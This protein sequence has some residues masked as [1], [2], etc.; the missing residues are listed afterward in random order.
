M[1]AATTAVGT[2]AYTMGAGTAGAVRT[3]AR[4]SAILDAVH[5]LLADVGYAALSI[6]AVAARAGASK[7]TIYRHWQ[8]KR[9]LVS[10][11]L[12]ARAASHPA[13]PSDAVDL[14]EDLVRL[15]ALLAG[16]AE[17]EDVAALVSLLGAAQQDPVIA[18][19][20]RVTALDRRRQDCRD[21]VQRAIGRGE[22]SSAS[23]APLLFELVLGQF[24]VRNLVGDGRF[25]TSDQLA[26]VDAVLVPALSAADL[27]SRT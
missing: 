21:V 18:E 24:L 14:R 9:S 26:F 4:R 6:D 15:V 13:M 5:E 25:P 12:V 20:V 16:I 11:A 7:A 22:L 8:D 10:A 3:A 17:H 23:L 2:M 19:T 1:L 27:P